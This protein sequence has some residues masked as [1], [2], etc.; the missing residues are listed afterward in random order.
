MACKRVD[1]LTVA[2]LCVCVASCAESAVENVDK[3]DQEV[4]DRIC[5]SEYNVDLDDG[6]NEFVDPK[7]YVDEHGDPLINYRMCRRSAVDKYDV[8]INAV[9]DKYCGSCE[10]TCKSPSRCR[11]TID[12]DSGEATYAC[13]CADGKELCNGVCVDIMTNPNFCGGCKTICPTD[14]TGRQASCVNGKCI[15]SGGAVFIDGE[16][17]DTKSDRNHCGAIGNKCH[18]GTTC[19]NG[20][21]SPCPEGFVLVEGGHT[22][23]VGGYDPDD[24]KQSDLEA[25]ESVS[26]DDSVYKTVLSSGIKWFDTV[27]EAI[28]DEAERSRYVFKVM[29]RR[30]KLTISRDFC[31]MKYE[32]H[33]NA[34]VWFDSPFDL[35]QTKPVVDTWDDAVSLANQYTRFLNKTK[36]GDRALPY[37]YGPAGED[38][39]CPP[40]KCEMEAS[41]RKDYAACRGVRLPS[42]YEWEYAARGGGHAAKY[43]TVG[44]DMTGSAGSGFVAVPQ[45]PVGLAELIRNYAW[46]RDSDVIGM[47][48]NVTD[49]KSPNALGLY[50][51]QG[52]VSEWTNDALRNDDFKNINAAEGVIPAATPLIDPHSYEARTG[53]SPVFHIVRGCS[54]SSRVIQCRDGARNALSKTTSYIGQRYVVAP[55]YDAEGNLI[56]EK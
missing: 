37:C 45:T 19:D 30:R 41:Y 8:C 31:M 17:V 56:V 44:V 13:G 43:Q 34:G 27:K 4:V 53:E 52:N 23:L 15:C 7:D 49:T 11:Q 26:N 36:K 54:V 47:T 40:G 22:I 21:C 2:S 39:K 3:E 20:K 46:Y 32:M 25:I 38:G 29:E 55:I 10:V 12:S 18:Y 9:T 1:I 6:F 24:I 35:H 16:C 50:N 14:Q 33:N 48:M 28:Q 51:M 42:E 5:R